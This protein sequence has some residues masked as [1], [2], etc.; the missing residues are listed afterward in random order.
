MHIVGLHLIALVWLAGFDLG[1]GHGIVQG[2]FGQEAELALLDQLSVWW[3]AVS[4][5]LG[6]VQE[7]EASR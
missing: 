3:Q 2:F 4:R 7:A 5:S 1:D 6:E